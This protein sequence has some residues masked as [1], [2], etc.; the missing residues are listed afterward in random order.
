[1]GRDACVLTIRIWIG[2][3]C[4]RFSFFFFYSF[5]V[6]FGQVIGLRHT[7]WLEPTQHIFMCR[8]HLYGGLKIYLYS[9]HV[10]HVKLKDS[11]W[12]INVCIYSIRLKLKLYFYLFVCLFGSI[13]CQNYQLV[14]Y[15]LETQIT[16][17]YLR[18]NILN[19]YSFIF[20]L[21]LAFSLPMSLSLTHL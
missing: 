16:F 15:L 2:E 8:T 20:S 13:Q 1:M 12:K 19:A 10:N 17:F 11:R 6:L 18:K 5:Y 14:T 9:V 7:I 3:G 21:T 4:H